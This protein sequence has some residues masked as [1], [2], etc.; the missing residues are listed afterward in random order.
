M[1]LSLVVEGPQLSQQKSHLFVALKC[2]DYADFFRQ[3]KVKHRIAKRS[4]FLVLKGSN[5][6][7]SETMVQV[8]GVFKTVTRLLTFFEICPVKCSL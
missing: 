5:Y 7:Q 8:F 2:V 6:V 1:V 4:S 3:D